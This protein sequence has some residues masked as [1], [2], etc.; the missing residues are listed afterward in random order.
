M[1][2]TKFWAMSQYYAMNG[3]KQMYFVDLALP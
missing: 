1:C 2:Y 3:V